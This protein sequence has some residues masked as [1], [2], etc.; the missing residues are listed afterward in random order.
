MLT[1]KL[2]DVSIT[3]QRADVGRPVRVDHAE[4]EELGWRRTR[5]GGVC[6]RPVLQVGGLLL[7]LLLFGVAVLWL[8]THLVVHRLL[9]T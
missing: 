3:G 4:G 9:L 7:L 1:V 8:R 6:F 2:E 5:L